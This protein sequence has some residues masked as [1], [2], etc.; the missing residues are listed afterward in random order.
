[1][2][3]EA[4]KT[5]LSSNRIVGLHDLYEDDEGIYMIT[6]YYEC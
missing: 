2:E 5:L 4:L 6:H 1:M 3:I